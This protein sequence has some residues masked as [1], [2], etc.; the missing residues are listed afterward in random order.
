M[1]S[2]VCDIGELFVM[3]KPYKIR[4]TDM[5]RFLKALSVLITIAGIFLSLLDLKGWIP[6][7]RYK[8]SDKILN[9]KDGVLPLDT[10]YLNVF[11]EELFFSK[12]P[13][14]RKYMSEFNGL[15]IK[16]LMLDSSRF[17]GAVYIMH[18][19]GGMI[20]ICSFKEL[21]DWAKNDRRVAWIGWGLVVG[22]TVVGWLLSYLSRRMRSSK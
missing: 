20:N 22:G 17:W 18:K 12:Q 19:S 7:P 8:L 3:R 2:L 9:L 6:N 15:K 10:P 5:I 14:Y 1:K 4:A 13:Q 21:E 11:L 16:D